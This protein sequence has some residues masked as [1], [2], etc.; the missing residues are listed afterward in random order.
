MKVKGKTT[1][2]EY[3]LGEGIM[4]AGVIKSNQ[5]EN[6]TAMAGRGAAIEEEGAAED[7][8]IFIL[9]ELDKQLSYLGA[10]HSL[11]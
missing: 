3:G 6:H 9:P 7:T 10:L 11:S 4:N 2:T 8:R 1:V 5:L